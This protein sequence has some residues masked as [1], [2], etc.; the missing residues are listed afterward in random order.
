MNFGTFAKALGV[1]PSEQTRVKLLLTHSFFIGIFVSTYFSFANGAF[2]SVFDLKMLPLA[3]LASGVSGFLATWL[4]SWLQNR[5]PLTRLLVLTLFFLLA[6]ALSFRT[7]LII[8]EE[9]R[10]LTFLIFIWAGPFLSLIGLQ[11]WTMVGNMFDL[12][13]GKRLFGLIGSGDVVSS[14]IGYMS[15]P[16]LLLWMEDSSNLLVIGSGGLLLGIFFQM[17]IIRKFGEQINPEQGDSDLR[18]SRRQKKAPKHRPK[19]LITNPYFAIV[20]TVMILSVVSSYLVDYGFMGAVRIKYADNPK[21][22]TSFIGGFFAAIKLA[23]LLGKTLLTGKVLN[24]FGIRFGLLILPFILLFFAAWAAV[25]GTVDLWSDTTT[26]GVGMM[27]LIPLAFNKLFDRFIRRSIEEPSFKILYQPLSNHSRIWLQTQTEGSAKQVAVILVGTILL[28]GSWFES[29]GILQ[30]AYILCLLLSLWIWLGFKMAGSY[31]KMLRKQ[32]TSYERKGIKKGELAYSSVHLLEQALKDRDPYRVLKAVSI[33]E[34]IEPGVLRQHYPSL[35]NSPSM[36]VQRAVIQ[37]ILNQLEFEL[38][39]LLEELFSNSQDEQLNKTL[40]QLQQHFQRWKAI[41]TKELSQLASAAD[42]KQREIAAHLLRQSK[43]GSQKELL[44]PL[45]KDQ[46]SGVACAALNAISREEINNYSDVLIDQLPKLTCGNIASRLLGEESDETIFHL[47]LASKRYESNPLMVLRIARL[48]GGIGSDK[49][50]SLLLEYQNHPDGEVRAMAMQ[51]LRLTGYKVGEKDLPFLKEKI[52]KEVRFSTWLLAGINELRHLPEY[53]SLCKKLLR[54]YQ[55]AL[56]NVFELLSFLYET[57]AIQQ[58]QQ[59]LASGVREREV[60]ALEMADLVL[61]EDLKEWVFPLIDSL[62]VTEKFRNLNRLFPQQ[63]LSPEK[64]LLDIVNYDFSMVA[65]W[66][67]AEAIRLLPEKEEAIGNDL[68]A[69]AFSPH[70]P[71][72]EAA[73]LAMYKMNPK[74]YFHYLSREPVAYQ[75]YLNNLVQL[76]SNSLAPLSVAQIT[77]RLRKVN[78]LRHMPES[79]LLRLAPFTQQLSLHP[80]DG[81]IELNARNEI[82]TVLEGRLEVRYPNGIHLWFG[83]GEMIGIE[84]LGDLKRSGFRVFRPTTLLC[85]QVAKFYELVHIQPDMA[86]ELYRRVLHKEPS[87]ARTRV[88]ARLDA[89]LEESDVE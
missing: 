83:P 59:N 72:K 74:T 20:F 80:D 12:R 69:N 32:L 89:L 25:A 28:I 11:F 37:G 45:L 15:I 53:A 63:K 71:V 52:R 9:S 66:I 43:E 79:M 41:T 60:L 86:A 51:S 62:S 33:L 35:L 23:E 87:M 2:L 65:P 54:A 19:D 64:R 29:F 17:V 3:Y 42:E 77:S 57:S 36:D 24:R 39:P 76:N 49:A 47:E 4:F 82:F 44:S 61:D 1:K 56:G 31:K 8:L 27:L 10:W 85:I 16:L 55:T 13:Q 75:N 5:I 48:L 34:K 21:A 30:A 14:I 7:G 6:L 68:V 22:M 38:Q 26:A 84:N 46:D 18:P 67:K 50:Q 40:N 70:P 78:V 73:F 58:I 88:E 81:D